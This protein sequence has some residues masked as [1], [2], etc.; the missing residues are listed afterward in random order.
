MKSAETC[1]RPLCNKLYTYLYHHIVVLDKYI[2]SS[3]VYYKHNGDDEPYERSVSFDIFITAGPVQFLSLCALK[4]CRSVG[5]LQCFRCTCGFHLQ[6]VMSK[7]QAA[8][9]YILRSLPLVLVGHIPRNE[10]T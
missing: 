6:G 4:P 2:Q 5:C 8:T 3:L 7:V 9:D 10:L 1:G